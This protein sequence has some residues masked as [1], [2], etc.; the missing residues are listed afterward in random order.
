MRHGN[1]PCKGEKRRNPKC[2]ARESAR[3]C[4]FRQGWHRPPGC[5]KAS[6]LPCGRRARRTRAD[7]ASGKRRARTSAGDGKRRKRAGNGK[8]RLHNL[9]RAARRRACKKRASGARCKV[10]SLAF[11]PASQAHCRMQGA[12]GRGK[13]KAREIQEKGARLLH[14]GGGFF[15]FRD[16]RRPVFRKAGLQHVS[17]CIFRRACHGM[18][19]LLLLFSVVRGIAPA[20]TVSVCG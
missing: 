17:T 1:K 12:S 10:A 13:G 4:G 18:P 6:A 19:S 9:R 7:A 2:F 20:G 11:P 5:G 3:T 16:G 8:R 15:R 14:L